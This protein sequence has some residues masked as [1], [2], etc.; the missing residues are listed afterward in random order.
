MRQVIVLATLLLL[1]HASAVLA[2]PEIREGLWEVS[3]R[4]E[5]GGQ[6]MSA[7]PIVA[8]QCVS[9]QSVQELMTK[10]GG[11]GACQISDF[12][13]TGTHARWNLTC[14]GQMDVTGTGET[15]IM[16]DQFSGRM[17]LVVSMSGQSVPMVQNF[18]ARRVGECQ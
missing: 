15:E 7:A 14:S 1:A 11:A 3:V 6:P 5:V 2:A 17:D 8:R 10:M 16:D 4:G 12:Q 18:Q 9:K 13:Q